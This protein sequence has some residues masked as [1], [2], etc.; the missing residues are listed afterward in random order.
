VPWPS[1]DE[2]WLVLPRKYGFDIRPTA[3]HDWKNLVLLNR[4]EFVPKSTIGVRMGNG[5][6]AFTPDGNWLVYLDTDSAGKHAVFR[7]PL[8][9]GK[10]ER[11]ADFSTDSFEA[12]LSISPD[13]RR[14]VAESWEGLSGFETWS[15]ENFIPVVTKQ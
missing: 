2:R 13:G 1:P 6:F 14:V 7:V 9:G 15:L 12:S 3:G 10:P 8:T 5:G 4:G 11:L